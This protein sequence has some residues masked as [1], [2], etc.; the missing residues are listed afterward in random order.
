MYDEFFGYHRVAN[1]K[2]SIQYERAYILEESH[3]QSYRMLP[4]LMLGGFWDGR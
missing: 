1:A 2:E 4:E 3:V